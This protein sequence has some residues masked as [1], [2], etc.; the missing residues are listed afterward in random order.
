MIVTKEY[1]S[2]N[3]VDSLYFFFYQG[4]NATVAVMSYS[5]YD[6]EVKAACLTWISVIHLIH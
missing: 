6:I 3:E 1:M 2:E 5:G 4:Q